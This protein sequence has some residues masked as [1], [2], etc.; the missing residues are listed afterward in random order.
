MVAAPSK[1][2]AALENSTRTLTMAA[3]PFEHAAALSERKMITVGVTDSEHAASLANSTR[4]LALEA[5]P[6]EDEAALAKRK[7]IAVVADGGQLFSWEL[8]S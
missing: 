8:F 3:P 6:S 2:V 7:M 5:A 4:I 1:H